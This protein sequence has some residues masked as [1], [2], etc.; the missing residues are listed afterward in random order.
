MVDP[1]EDLPTWVTRLDQALGLTNLVSRDAEAEEIAALRQ[2]R[3]PRW[4]TTA[5]AEFAGD[6]EATGKIVVTTYHSSKGREWPYVILPAL[7]EGVAP[8]WPLDYGK[9]YLPNTDMVAEERRLFY[10]A[11]TR[12]QR[13]AVLIYTPGGTP[14]ATNP[15]FHISPS[16][17]ITNLPGFTWQVTT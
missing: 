11:L 3:G 5:I 2:L 9:P 4:S 16:R 1:Y 13:A 12:A 8:D 6:V 10:V 15:T 17:F 7:Q 14:N